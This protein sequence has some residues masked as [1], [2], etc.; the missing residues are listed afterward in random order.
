MDYRRNLICL[1][2]LPIERF[3]FQARC[4]AGIPNTKQPT[5]QQKYLLNAKNQDEEAAA[6]HAGMPLSFG[7]GFFM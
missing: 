6:Q 4:P 3:C 7:V 5:S 1:R 2:R